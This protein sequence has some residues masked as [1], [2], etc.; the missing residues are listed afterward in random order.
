VQCYF[1]LLDIENS[2]PF[3]TYTYLGTL[4]I[5]LH[6]SCDHASPAV[7]LCEEKKGP[8]IKHTNEAH[9]HYYSTTLY[10][11]SWRWKNN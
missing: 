8:S 5:I 3:T 10:P 4:R 9:A 2:Y 7:F 6:A 1:I 11:I